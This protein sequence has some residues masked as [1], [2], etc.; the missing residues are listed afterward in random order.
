M[1]SYTLFV[2]RFLL[3]GVKGFGPTDPN[4]RYFLDLA[5]KWR[6][7]KCSPTKGTLS[8]MRNGE[9]GDAAR[10]AEAFSRAMFEHDDD[11]V[12]VLLQT[13]VISPLPA[14]S[15]I[16]ENVDKDVMR[17]IKTGACGRYLMPQLKAIVKDVSKM[18]VK[19]Y[20]NIFLYSLALFDACPDVGGRPFLDIFKCEADSLVKSFEKC[21]SRAF[22]KK[23]TIKRLAERLFPHSN[24]AKKDWD[25]YK[26]PTRFVA[27]DFLRRIADIWFDDVLLPGLKDKLQSVR[28]ESEQKEMLESYKKDIEN[29]YRFV[30]AYA[31]IMDRVKE[32]HKI[33]FRDMAAKRYDA[34]LE[35]TEALY[36]ISD[37]T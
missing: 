25:A 2:I 9:H 6:D 5:A 18:N 13:T 34:F 10:F 31:L 11:A 30:G 37:K 23:Y 22:R 35:E 3:K 20:C 32:K 17:F 21:I 33:D 4:D 8:R 19:D 28:D 16:V 12:F 27:P 36:R 14:Y 29:G 24:E 26:K 15:N 7:G 1:I